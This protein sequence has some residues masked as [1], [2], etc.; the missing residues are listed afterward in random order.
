V[1]KPSSRAVALADRLREA[2]AR[3]VVVV[4]AIADERWRALPE[5]GIW[6]ISKDA[7]HVVEASGYHEWIVRYTIGEKVSSRRPALERRAMTSRHSQHEAAELIRLRADDAAALLL[8]LT[9]AELDLPTRPPRAKAEVLA[10]TIDRV[11]IGHFDTHRA[12]IEA[13]LLAAEVR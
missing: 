1:E 13:K 4:E 5:T 2:A 10:E 11:F 12:A 8:G 7:E 6:S 3:L 9:D